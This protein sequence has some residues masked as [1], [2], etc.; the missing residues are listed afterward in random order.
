M[1]L[2]DRKLGGKLGAVEEYEAGNSVDPLGEGFQWAEEDPEAIHAERHRE[3]TEAMRRTE[4]A[5][6]DSDKLF[7][8]RRRHQLASAPDKRR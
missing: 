1:P 5:L 2:K 6:E 4:R 8:I 7:A 3:L